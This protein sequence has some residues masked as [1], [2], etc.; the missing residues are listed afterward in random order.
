MKKSSI[1]AFFHSSCIILCSLVAS[2]PAIAQVTP[3]GTTSTTV[4]S[5]DGSNFVINDGDRP[6]GGANLFHSFQDFSVPTNGSA[7]FN[8]AVDIQNIFSRVTGGDISSIDGLLGANGA[9]NLFL[10]NPAGIIFGR[11]AILNIGGSFF[12]STADSLLFEDGTEFIATDGQNKPMLTIDAPIGL[13]FRDEPGDIVNQSFALQVRPGATLALIGGD[14]SFN[15][16]ILTALGGHLELGSV[17][18]DSEVFLGQTSPGFVVGYEEVTDF[19]NIQLNQQAIL[20]TSGLVGG[21]LNIQGEQVSIQEGSQILS[22]TQGD[23]NGG[24]IVINTNNLL[25]GSEGKIVN[26]TSG[27]GNGGD[28]NIIATE[29]VEIV[30]T[31]FNDLQENVIQGVLSGGTSTEL[32]DQATG[33]FVNTSGTGQAGNATIDTSSLRMSNGASI[34][35][36]TSFSTIS[37]DTSTEGRGGDIKINADEEIELIGSALL[38]GSLLGSTALGGDT[39][40]EAKN[41][42]VRDGGLIL[43]ATLGSGDGGDIKINVSENVELSNTLAEAIIPTGI[44]ANSSFSIGQA[45]D[46]KINASN[47]FTYEGAVINNNSGALIFNQPSPLGGVLPLPGGNGG[48]I[49]INVSNLIELKGIG[50]N[51]ITTSGISSTAF[52]GNSSAGDINIATKN[53]VVRDGARIDAATTGSGEGGEITIEARESVV[54]SGTSPIREPVI[55][56]EIPS[57]IAATSGRIDLPSEATGQAGNLNITTRKLTIRDGANISVAS[58]NGSVG[59]AGNLN[60]VAESVTLDNEGAINAATVSGQ[61]GNIQLQVDNTINLQNN[62]LISAQAT[63]DANGGNVTINTDFIIAASNQNNDIIA[64]ASQGMGGNINITAEGIFGLE[65][66]SSTPPNQTND[67]DASSE[68][69]LDGTVLINTPDVGTFKEIIEA[70][71]IAQIQTLG[72]N[73]CARKETSGASSFIITGKGGIP[74]Q[75]TKPLS[76]NAIFLEGESASISLEQLE[77]VKQQQIQPLVTAKGEIYPARGIVFLENGDIILTPYATSSIQRIP[78]NS[79]NCRKS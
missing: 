66:R 58:V 70:P 45:G 31:G 15:G 79:A 27:S 35:S 53:L 10:I 23:L 59:A 7:S 6:E 76:S 32:L 54:I 68:F 37:S 43:S 41:L 2:K 3:D 71:E 78:K 5:P 38:N 69:G 73:A 16:G 48:T 12:G 33:I 46:V 14:L 34:F 52:A 24:D 47:L 51:G 28:I 57:A 60:V 25:I 30:G 72:V 44:I 77:K 20:N 1:I 17:K 22:I 26:A 36:N 42:D 19:G 40:V 11:N 67:I 4:V 18:S 63:N 39:I 75:P 61:G 49:D 56:S 13:S 62:S 8:N 55:I 21:T 64:S 29:G 65:E 9:A 50:S 74:P